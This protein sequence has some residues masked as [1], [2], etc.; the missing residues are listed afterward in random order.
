MADHR[1]GGVYL[2]GSAG[3]GKTALSSLYFDAIPTS[4]KR[5]FHFHEFLAA[6]DAFIASTRGSIDDA[7]DE[8]VG[9]VVAIMFD[10]FHVHDVADAIYLTAMLRRLVGNGTLL[11]ATSNYAPSELLPNPLM[12]Q[13]FQPAIE[14]IERGLQVIRIGGGTDYRL[15][16]DQHGDMM[17]HGFASGTWSSVLPDACVQMSAEHIDLNGQT[18]AIQR[19]GVSVAIAFAELCERPLGAGQYLALARRFRAITVVDVPNLAE[20][21]RDPLR[22]LC[23][24]IDICCDRDVAVHIVSP[25]Y[26][27]DI[28]HALEPP[29]DVARAL[30]RLSML[31]FTPALDHAPSPRGD[32]IGRRPGR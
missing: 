14:M 13:R 11:I 2:W 32:V 29:P 4:A 1:S 28:L 25:G 21:E 26:P 27:R 12:H 6:I 30:S 19:N 20:G 10:E 24:V 5:R 31:R 15:V 18:V 8:L 23:S 16:R 7:L 9:G 17:S 22:R 3:R